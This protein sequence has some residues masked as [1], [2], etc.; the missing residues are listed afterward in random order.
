[1]RPIALAIR[2]SEGQLGLANRRQL[3]AAG[4]S[5]GQ[6]RHLIA[7]GT[8][9][10]VFTSVYRLA[11]STASFQQ[12]CLAAVMAGGEGAVVSH[13]CAAALR[14]LTPQPDEI[15]LTVPEHRR[16]RRRGIVAHH[17]DILRVVD[18]AMWD[19]IPVTS[20]PRT[21]LD[22]APVF[23]DAALEVLADD[24]FRRLLVTPDALASYLDDPALANKQGIGRL[25]RIAL[26]RAEH[27]VPESKLE[28]PMLQLINAYRLPQPLRQYPTR[29]F[30][31]EVR[32]DFA[33]PD[34][35]VA[36]EPEG[37][38]PRWG[39]LRWQSTHDRYNALELGEWRVLRFTWE[40]VTERPA[41]VA[42]VIAEKLALR[43]TGWRSMKKDAAIRARRP[44]ERAG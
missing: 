15:S 32:F 40:D 38:A 11:G 33:Y 29:V 6:I 28:T 19:A 20:P 27:G 35:R 8:L 24:A 23:D 31:R 9:I 37:W 14:T 17:S 5:D 30:G 41:Y 2:V 16:V 39:R 12:R 21:L 25:R 13:L 1:M 43:P 42:F 34:R 36:I 44:V 18:V 10:A 4:L 22:I 26:D 7:T 3:L